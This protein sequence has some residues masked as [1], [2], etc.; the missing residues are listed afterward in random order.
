MS[1]IRTWLMIFAIVFVILIASLFG[2]IKA[3]QNKIIAMT[4]EDQTFFTTAKAVFTLN[5]DSELEKQLKAASMKRKYNHVSIY[6]QEE[7]EKL[8]P[9]TIETLEWAEDKSSEVLGDYDKS[10]ID[11]IFMSKDDLEQLSNIDGAGGYYSNFDK[12][13]GIYVQP[14]DMEAILQKL[15]TPLYFF[16]KKVLHEYAHYATFRKIEE[17]GAT[18]GAFPEWFIEGIAEYVANDKTEVPFESNQFEPLP[19][20]SISWNDDWQEARQISTANPYMQSYFTINYMVQVYGE[21]VVEELITKT[22]ESQDFYKTLE[23]LTR[24]TIPEFEEDAFSYYQ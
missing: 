7:N 21:N 8:V 6:F 12:V 10:S 4:G 16:Q 17:A 9:L 23:S 11:M 3:F 14:E 19:L 1:K 24:R 20:K 5:Y 13:M 15:E 2:V 18:S 22:K